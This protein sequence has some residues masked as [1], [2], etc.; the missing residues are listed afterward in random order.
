MKKKSPIILILKEGTSIDKGRTVSIVWTKEWQNL[1]SD[2]CIGYLIRQMADTLLTA[3]KNNVKT[4]TKKKSKD[5]R[6]I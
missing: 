5:S 6:I 4:P 1:A 3:I 2:E